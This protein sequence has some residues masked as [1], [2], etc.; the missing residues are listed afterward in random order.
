[1]TIRA[2]PPTSPQRTQQAGRQAEREQRQMGSPPGCRQPQ[3]PVD[4]LPNPNAL[5][6][7]HP[8]PVD[9]YPGIPRHQI[10]RH[11]VQRMHR[12]RSRSP[13]P[14][15]WPPAALP[16]QLPPMDYH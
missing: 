5:R 13:P 7:H 8:V 2:T 10:E 14:P 6:Y 16:N 12:L 3:Q 9:Q 1:I 4:L 15:M 11:H